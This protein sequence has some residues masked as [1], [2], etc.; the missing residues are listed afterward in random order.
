L[1][2]NNHK[3]WREERYSAIATLIARSSEGYLPTPSSNTASSPPRHS[4]AKGF[5]ASVEVILTPCQKTAFPL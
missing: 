5:V 3:S 1:R 2:E 4:L